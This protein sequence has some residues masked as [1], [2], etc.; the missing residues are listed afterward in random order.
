AEGLTVSPSELPGRRA[1]LGERPESMLVRYR[2]RGD[3][4]DNWSIL[5]SAPVFDDDGKVLY[6][7]NIFR[8][9]T[10]W[11]RMETALEQAH[12]NLSRIF[13]SSPLA[14]IALDADG[15][16][17][18]WNRGAEQIFG[19]SREEA[20][21]HILP[22][23]PQSRLEEFRE[24]VR[25]TIS[26]EHLAG[27]EAR[28]QRK[29]G[30][31][32]DVAMWTS[33]IVAPDGEELAVAMTAD[34]TERKR[35]E[36]QNRFLAEA[37]E[38]LSSSLDATTN[39]RTL[40]NLAVPTIADWC[41]IDLAS[42]EGRL[43][44]LI[45]AHR[46]PEKVQWAEELRRRYP[47][48]PN[49]P[50]GLFQMLRTGNPELHE[51]VDEALLRQ[52]ASDEQHFQILRE[53]GLRSVMIVPLKGRDR[54]LGAISLVSSEPG[55][56][57]GPQDLAFAEELARRAALSLENSLLYQSEQEARL[58]AERAVRRSMALLEV[59]AALSEA[60][61]PEAVAAVIVSRGFSAL[62]AGAGAVVVIEPGRRELRALRMEG[63]S[64]EIIEQWSHRSLADTPIAA[65]ITAKEALLFESRA[66][67]LNRFPS[68]RD[69][70]AEE[71][72][73]AACVPLLLDRKAIG[74]I[75]LSFREQ[76]RFSIEDQT[77]LLTLARQCAQAVDR[78]RLYVAERQ[79]REAAEEASRAKDDFLA[80]LSHELRTPLTATIG[81]ARLL[82]MTPPDQETLQVGLESIFR[83]AQTQAR[84]VDDILDVSR[85]I[86][87]KMRID[88][89]PVNL[90][91]VV[92]A[93]RDAVRS[94][95]DAKG[96]A[97]VLRLTRPLQV[98]GDADRLQQVVWNLLANAIKF[99]PAGATV[100]VSLEETA[101][102]V[103]LQV[104]DNGR[105]IEPHLL[106]HVFDRF[107][108]GDSS[109][110]RVSGGLGLGLSIVR[111]LVELHGGEVSV[112]SE[113]E[114]RGT[115]FTILLPRLEQSSALLPIREPVR[116][117]VTATSSLSGHRLLVV[118][119]EADTR[120]LIGRMLEQSGA[121]VRCVESAAEA[122]RILDD[123]HPDLIVSDLAMPEADG[124]ALLHAVRT[125]PE[126][127]EV[128]VIA[129]TAYGREEDQAS[130]LASGF[131]GYL[132]KPIEPEQLTLSIASILARPIPE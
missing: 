97:L 12:E 29:D 11:R 52:G 51:T 125:R 39:L 58:L 111:H 48:D 47:S 43:E 27:N 60:N 15:I 17:R 32:I 38:L 61:T 59:A 88:A 77:F 89:V 57:Y 131:Q 41:S 4:A 98:T 86:T 22:S 127:M 95:A 5:S 78:A 53:L 124:Y 87:G 18:L 14:I 118:E 40:A 99:S 126:G 114:G 103:R 71:F 94:A 34:M 62:G 107:R 44:R 2:R 72:E 8:D 115:T 6:A 79:A 84:I 109:S 80:T 3:E 70:M 35:V 121:E 92:E 65:A 116:P 128:P 28:R 19:W 45:I 68:I 90:G 66:D 101:A 49:S 91:A 33:K 113:G 63:Y 76:R 83:T 100:E 104:R 81:W 82:T 117:E 7:I 110:S 55:R 75:A 20:I 85:I 120:A 16:V 119:D 24:N 108:Q 132:R 106:P 102:A 93:S 46:D 105:G 9:V 123:Y 74:C 129:L 21:G 56:H 30:S 23:V 42:N 67:I 96:I 64:S 1:L 54:V 130:V 26:G 13:E 37:S 69:H 50:T 25:R 73:A 31:P 36:E 112:E 122:L 10:D